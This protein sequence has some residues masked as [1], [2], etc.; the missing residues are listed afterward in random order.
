[1]ERAARGAIGSDLD[2]LGNL[3]GGSGEMDRTVVASFKKCGFRWGGDWAC[4]DPMHFELGALL[5]E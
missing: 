3:R 1:M 4:T 5:T 2:V